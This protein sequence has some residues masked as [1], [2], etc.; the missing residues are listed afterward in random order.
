MDNVITIGK[1]LI[2][3]EHIAFVEPYDP[4]TNPK[5]QTSREYKARIVMINRDS[6]LTEQSPREFADAHSFRTL[7]GDQIATNPSVAFR[8]ETFEPADGFTPSK[9]FATRLLWRDRDG[10]DQSKLLVAPPETVLAVVVRGETDGQASKASASPMPHKDEIIQRP[11]R[12]RQ[13]AT[14]AEAPRQ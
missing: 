2:P 12:R 3:I 14:S 13:A 4:S 1:R 10:N 7:D 8:V 11:P 5:L 9:A 6:V